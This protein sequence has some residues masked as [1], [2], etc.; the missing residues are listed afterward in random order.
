M[1]KFD[2]RYLWTGQRIE[3][4]YDLLVKDV[5]TSGSIEAVDTKENRQRCRQIHYDFKGSSIYSKA[6]TVQTIVKLI[7]CLGIIMWSIF[8]QCH[9]LRKDFANKL[10]CKVFDYVHECAIPSNGLNLVIFD[11][12]NLVL[13][14]ILVVVAYNLNYHLKFKQPKNIQKIEYQQNN[15]NIVWVMVSKV[16]I[17]I[18]HRG[19]YF[20]IL[21]VF[22]DQRVQG[23]FPEMEVY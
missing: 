13:F 20:N 10:Q 3:K 12:V 6:Y 7:I 18:C 5:V 9:S 23:S 15:L 8:N 22:I 19:I 4:F 16:Y 2:C 11:M 17:Y 21:F 14:V 1:T